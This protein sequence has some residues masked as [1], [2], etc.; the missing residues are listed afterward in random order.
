MKQW[1]LGIQL[2]PEPPSFDRREMI[3]PNQ[4]HALN[5]EGSTKGMGADL[6]ERGCEHGHSYYECPCCEATGRD[7]YRLY[8]D[9]AIP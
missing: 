4:H 7:S 3:S 5:S 8:Y 1:E 2:D 9:T 6:T